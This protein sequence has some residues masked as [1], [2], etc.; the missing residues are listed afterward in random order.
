M[1]ITWSHEE[2]LDDLAMISKTDAR[3]NTTNYEYDAKGNIT[4]EKDP[5]AKEIITVWNQQF[6]CNRLERNMGQFKV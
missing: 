1:Q 2:G 4:L 3:G 5:Y 6:S